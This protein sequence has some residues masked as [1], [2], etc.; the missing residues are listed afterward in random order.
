MTS[1]ITALG[2]IF[3]SLD[4]STEASV[5]P[6]L[7]KTPPDLATNGNTCPGETMSLFFAF[8]CYLG[9]YPPNM[10]ARQKSET[11]TFFLARLEDP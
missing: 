4:I 10:C 2:L 6:A 5:C 11:M 7:S 1:Q 9:I 3:A 8:L